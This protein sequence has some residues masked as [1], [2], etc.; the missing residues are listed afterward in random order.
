MAISS[1]STIDQFL[2]ADEI[3]ICDQTKFDTVGE[4]LDHLKES[5]ELKDLKSISLDDNYI[6]FAIFGITGILF[7]LNPKYLNSLL[8]LSFA[9]VYSVSIFR[10]IKYEEPI[11]DTVTI[12]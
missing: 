11:I 12:D 4:V 6:P 2:D 5:K 8:V 9:A 1:T 7:T 3:F 10:G